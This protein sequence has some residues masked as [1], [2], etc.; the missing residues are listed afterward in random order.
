ML[1]KALMIFISFLLVLPLFTGVVGFA[2][3]IN[4]DPPSFQK[5]CDMDQ[6]NP[7]MPKCPLCHSSGSIVQLFYQECGPY[8]PT[9]VSSFIMLTES[10]LSDQGFAKAIFHPP[11]ITS[12]NH[13]KSFTISY[14]ILQPFERNGLIPLHPPLSKGGKLSPPFEKGR[15]GGISGKVLQMAIQLPSMNIVS[16]PA[17]TQAPSVQSPHL[18]GKG[19]DSLAK[20]S[21]KSSLLI[22]SGFTGDEKPCQVEIRKI[23]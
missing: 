5:P 18:Q 22:I 13:H 1:K 4:T 21:I 10:T 14:V 16:A 19:R 7:N 9:P 23:N 11:T 6:C 12:Q 2:Q 20:T 17:S 8:L 3:P 15:L